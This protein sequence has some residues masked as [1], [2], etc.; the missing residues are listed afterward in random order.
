MA[1][2]SVTVTCPGTNTYAPAGDLNGDGIVDQD[3]LNAVLANYWASSQWVYMT[4]PVS[5]GG[6][7]F[8]F[9]LTNATGWNFTVLASAISWTGPTCPTRLP[10]LPVLRRRGRQQRPHAHLPAALGRRTLPST[11]ERVQSAAT[12]AA[13]KNP[14]ETLESIWTASHR[15]G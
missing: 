6:G 1:T 11:R 15:S 3:E 12:F 8:Q 5:L 4:N 13:E 7:F 9:A 10:G 2:N 14:L